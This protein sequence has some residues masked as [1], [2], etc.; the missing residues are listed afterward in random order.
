MVNELDEGVEG[1][2]EGKGRRKGREGKRCWTY[3]YCRLADD[4]A[5]LL[6]GVGTVGVMS[7]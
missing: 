4:A 5:S 3:E 6:F 2:K 7:L 1:K